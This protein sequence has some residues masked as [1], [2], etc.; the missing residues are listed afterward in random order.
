VTVEDDALYRDMADRERA[1][2]D[3]I[4]DVEG[5]ETDAAAGSWDDGTVENAA[6][7]AAS[8]LGDLLKAIQARMAAIPPADPS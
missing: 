4:S 7:S 8:E 3:A 5:I 1:V 2:L 6:N